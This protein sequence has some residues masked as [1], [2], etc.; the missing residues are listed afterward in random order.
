MSIAESS[1]Q[2]SLIGP[3]ASTLESDFFQNGLKSG[4]FGKNTLQTRE[5]PGETEN[6]HKPGSRAENKPEYHFTYC[7]WSIMP[8]VLPES[9]SVWSGLTADAITRRL[10][11][12]KWIELDRPNPGDAFIDH[13]DSYRHS[14]RLTIRA[15]Q[16]LLLI[17][18]EDG[19]ES[20]GDAKR[21]VNQIA[22]LVVEE[23]DTLLTMKGCRDELGDRGP[24]I[25]SSMYALGFLNDLCSSFYERVIT[26]HSEFC[27]L[28]SPIIAS[29][30]D[31]FCNNWRNGDQWRYRNLPWQLSAALILPEVSSVI[32]D[33]A[34]IHDVAHTLW[35]SITPA[36]RLRDMELVHEP[37]LDEY[38]VCLRLAV[39]LIKALPEKGSHREKLQNLARWIVSRS[40]VE[41][42]SCLKTHD[43]AS[44]YWIAKWHD[45][46][47]VVIPPPRERLPKPTQWIVDGRK[48]LALF[49]KPDLVAPL[50]QEERDVLDKSPWNK[51]KMTQSR[52]MVDV[53]DLMKRV[54]SKSDRVLI[55]GESGT[56]KELVFRALREA[57]CPEQ[58]CVT[59]DCGAIHHDTVESEIFGHEKGAFTGATELRE[60]MLECAGAGTLFLDEIGNL[61][62]DLQAKLLRVLQER[63]FQRMGSKKD[64]KP[65]A[66]A[67]RLVT[68]TNKD[69]RE[70]MKKDL[71]REDLYHRIATWTLK[72]PPLRD[73]QEDVIPLAER[74][75]NE[76][77]T[78]GT[79]RRRK[80]SCDATKVLQWYLWPGNVR[81][82]ME[83]MTRL[84]GY[85]ESDEI[86][87]SDMMKTED[88]DFVEALREMFEK[89]EGVFSARD[90][91]IDVI[92]ETLK[93]TSGTKKDQMAAAAKAVGKSVSFT[94]DLLKRH[95]INVSNNSA[96]SQHP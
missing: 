76:E 42:L 48:W 52:A 13:W 30:E 7:G 45:P 86:T 31:F 79:Q 9:V 73:R 58:P 39:A 91:R 20:S 72:L 82:L 29:L 57:Y 33:Q 24:C 56:G 36:G 60:G 63:T 40:R 26:N 96:P 43:L 94:Y 14:V 66:F 61:A 38:E 65:L 47:T 90:P 28:A 5:A 75:L 62:L 80:L 10:G 71:F 54:A 81:E 34:L 83:M 3:I 51:T 59:V 50:T 87:V 2:E 15:A 89:K 70:M 11:N 46:T 53:L 27:R 77:D 23:K 92:L 85:S 19:D 25:I 32:H 18:K 35:D 17:L 41:Q 55:R 21:L 37:E 6:W 12:D 78:L 4:E 68:A 1:E 64:A 49:R 69:L 93:S 16:I 95:G 22:W 88:T 44:L 67:A 74:F 8:H 84:R